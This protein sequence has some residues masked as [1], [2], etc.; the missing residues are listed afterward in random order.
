MNTTDIVIITRA[1]ALS[2][3]FLERFPQ[4][5]ANVEEV[6]EL[7][8]LNTQAIAALSRESPTRRGTARPILPSYFW[9]P[10]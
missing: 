6:A 9:E 8:E 4:G 2:R 10:T 5:R 1:L 3:S 7:V